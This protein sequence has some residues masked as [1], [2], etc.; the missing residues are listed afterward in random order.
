MALGWISL[1][2]ISDI[3]HLLTLRDS[4][5][6]PFLRRGPW[7]IDLSQ[8]DG[9]MWNVLIMFLG[10][11][12]LGKPGMIGHCFPMQLAENRGLGKQVDEDTL[13]PAELPSVLPE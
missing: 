11:R 13:E 10:D 5:L 12:I 6:A 9:E 3:N 1:L 8:N 4:S 7:F 2:P